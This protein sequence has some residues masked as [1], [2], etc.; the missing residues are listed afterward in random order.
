MLK[1]FFSVSSKEETVIEEDET[2]SITTVIAVGVGGIIGVFIIA[3]YF[4]VGNI[5]HPAV[6]IASNIIT[7]ILIIQLTF[8]LEWK[9]PIRV[10]SEVQFWLFFFFALVTIFIYIVNFFMRLNQ[11]GLWIAS[12][13]SDILESVA[14]TILFVVLYVKQKIKH[15]GYYSPPSLLHSLFL[16]YLFFPL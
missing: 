4:L 1:L 15:R 7:I 6:T 3:S 5:D 8:S 11:G 16:S 14:S 13:V 2:L 10:A 9:K 12:S